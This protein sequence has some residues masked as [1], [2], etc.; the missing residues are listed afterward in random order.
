MEIAER[1]EALEAAA[2]GSQATEPFIG[3]ELRPDLM[4]GPSYE[5]E[6]PELVAGMAAG[7]AASK[8]AFDSPPTSS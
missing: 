3:S 6:R 4:G 7:D 8:R 5:P 2:G 1:L